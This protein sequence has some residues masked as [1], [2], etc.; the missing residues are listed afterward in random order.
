M[1]TKVKNIGQIYSLEAFIY[2]PMLVMEGLLLI[3]LWSLSF[4]YRLI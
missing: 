1:S 4:N 3:A 2:K